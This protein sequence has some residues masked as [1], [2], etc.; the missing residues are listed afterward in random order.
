[1]YGDAADVVAAELDHAG[2]NPGS[3][4]Y[5]ERSDRVADRARAVDCG[6]GRMERGQR[7]D[8]GGLDLHA[9]EAA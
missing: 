3:D 6:C 8:A 5:S 2:M 9:V 1:V 4:F 7:A